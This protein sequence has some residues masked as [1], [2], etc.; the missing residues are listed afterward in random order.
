MRQ[1]AVTEGDKVAAQIQLGF[2]VDAFDPNDIVNQMKGLLQTEINHLI[3]N[4]MDCPLLPT[5]ESS[6]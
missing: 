2:S 1:V 4:S 6:I 3:E 5:N